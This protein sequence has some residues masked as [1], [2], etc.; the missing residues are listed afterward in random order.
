MGTLSADV[1]VPGVADSNPVTVITVT[2]PSNCLVVALAI[3]VG[4]SGTETLT[5]TSTGRTWT[6]L[7]RSNDSSGATNEVWT[8]PVSASATFDIDVTDDKGSVFKRIKPAY[9]TD[10]SGNIPGTGAVREV[11][12]GNP[13]QV[14]STA[15][16]SLMFGQMIAGSASGVVAGQTIIDQDTTINGGT[17]AY[18]AFLLNTPSTSIGQALDIT[19]TLTG[20]DINGVEIVPATGPPPV[21]LPG[22][23]IYIGRRRRKVC[24]EWCLSR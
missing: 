3:G 14:V 5:I 11:N 22:S 17:A 24:N 2:P 13:I 1:S 12:N 19:L 20:F 18:Q 7:S 16:G 9:L 10:S 4:N 21:M 15:I 6:L 23:G 8:T